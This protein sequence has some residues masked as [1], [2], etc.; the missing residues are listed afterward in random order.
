MILYQSVDELLDNVI[1]HAH[2]TN[3]EVDLQYDD[4]DIILSIR[5][6]GQG[7]DTAAFTLGHMMIPDLAFLKSR[8]EYPILV[9]PLTSNQTLKLE[10]G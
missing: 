4:R 10:H 6:N 1:R 5:D 8:K 2:A 9:D 3:V 7:F